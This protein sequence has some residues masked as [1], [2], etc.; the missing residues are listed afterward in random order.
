LKNRKASYTKPQTH[1]KIQKDRTFWL[2]IPSYRPSQ[3]ENEK[4]K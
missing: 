4:Q 3:A 2:E 1:D